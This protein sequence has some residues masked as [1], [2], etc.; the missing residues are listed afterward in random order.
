MWISL[1][2][3]VIANFALHGRQM[4]F[5]VSWISSNFQALADLLAASQSDKGA[6]STLTSGQMALLN[7]N[8]ELVQDISQMQLSHIHQVLPR[9]SHAERV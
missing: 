5:L 8:L 3:K 6:R 9:M 4:D 1:R 2:T 7:L